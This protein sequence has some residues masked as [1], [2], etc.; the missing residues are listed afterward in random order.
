MLR[1]AYDLWGSELHNG[2]A[3]IPFRR[4]PKWRRVL[5]AVNG[6]FY[7]LQGWQV[8]VTKRS[9]KDR[10]KM[11]RIRN[12]AS[13]LKC[14]LRTIEPA[15]RRKTEW[16]CSVLIRCRCLRSQRGQRAPSVR[17]P[18]CSLCVCARQF[19]NANLAF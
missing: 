14:Q 7:V 1:L 11:N 19:A 10:C 13:W 4:P 9:A 8:S 5:A 12:N 2:Q 16:M 17:L 6:N 15:R 18:S 3:A